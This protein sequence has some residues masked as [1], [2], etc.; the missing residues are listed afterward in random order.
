MLYF[1][2]KDLKN[3]IYTF[4]LSEA[5][6]CVRDYMLYTHVKNLLTRQLSLENTALPYVTPP[7]KQVTPPLSGLLCAPVGDEP[8]G[9]LP[10]IESSTVGASTSPPLG[11]TVRQV[12]S[13]LHRDERMA[14]LSKLRPC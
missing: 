11:A 6:A 1:K 12:A 14:E 2:K 13:L 3:V 7:P 4:L 8:P 10:A 9:L 5:K